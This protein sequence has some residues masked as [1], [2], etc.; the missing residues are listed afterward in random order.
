ML[1]PED[2]KRGRSPGARESSSGGSRSASRKPGEGSRIK[3]RE[4]KK[5]RRKKSTSLKD[6]EKGVKKGGVNSSS[7]VET[8]AAPPNLQ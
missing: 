4:K 3:G 2:T 6:A 5:G 8:P 7:G 1:H